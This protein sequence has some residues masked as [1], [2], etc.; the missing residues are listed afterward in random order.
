MRYKYK[1]KTKEYEFNK[2]EHI[3]ELLAENAEKCG[4]IGARSWYP[5][6]GR[7]QNKVK[8][9][10]IRDLIELHNFK[11]SDAKILFIRKELKKDAQ[12]T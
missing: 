9:M 5:I 6:Y 3:L 1:S 12:A 10:K 4:I 7:H 2:K 8:R 11:V